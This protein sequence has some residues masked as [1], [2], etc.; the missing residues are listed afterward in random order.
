MLGLLISGRD[1]LI[2]AGDHVLKVI[3][4][5]VTRSWNNF[6]IMSF[7]KF[8]MFLYMVNNTVNPSRTFHLQPAIDMNAVEINKYLLFSF[9]VITKFTLW[10]H[11][12][13]S[14]LRNWPWNIL[15]CWKNRLWRLKKDPRPSVICRKFPVSWKQSTTPSSTSN[16]CRPIADIFFQHYFIHMIIVFTWHSRL[17]ASGAWSVPYQWIFLRH[18]YKRKGQRRKDPPIL[19][20]P[21]RSKAAIFVNLHCS[22]E[23]VLYWWQLNLIH[24]RSSC[25]LSLVQTR[26]WVSERTENEAFFFSLSNKMSNFYCCRSTRIRTGIRLV[27][28]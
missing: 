3:G 1:T 6:T 4:L 23:A 18:S 10:L 16:L 9:E 5:Q 7:K 8:G 20:A 24:P 15:V 25:K 19:F 14:E 27:L 12:L 11:K 26:L 2:E 21:Y 28:E 22:F 17:N 13:H